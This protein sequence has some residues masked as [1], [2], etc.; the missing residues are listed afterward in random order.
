MNINTFKFP[1]KLV[2]TSLVALSIGFTGCL[3]DSEKDPDPDP[4]PTETLTSKNVTLGAQTASAGSSLDLDGPT[5]YTMSQLAANSA[6][7]DLVFA[8]STSASASAI[9]SP[10]AAKNG[11]GGSAGFAFLADL[12]PANKTDIKPV[13]DK[14]KFAS[15]DTPA[16]LQTLWDSIS[17]VD[18]GRVLVAKDD[19]IMA[20][21]NLGKIVIFTVQE[22]VT[23]ASGSTSLSLKAKY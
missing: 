8:Y 16:K 7:I 2:Y 12:S 5:V 3:T 6:A 21:S 13:N 17:P 20:K 9:Y 19:V 1:R 22:V 23:G 14:S 10:D 11:I 18:P 15:T 4:T